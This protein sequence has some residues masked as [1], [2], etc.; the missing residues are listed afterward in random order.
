MTTSQFQAI[1]VIPAAGVGARMGADVPKQ[2]LSCLGKPLMWY[3]LN[4]MQ[5]CDWITEIFVAISP[6]DGYWETHIGDQFSKVS[7]VAGGA[8]RAESVLN[9]LTE[10]RQRHDSNIWTLVHDAARPC[11]FTH[12]LQAIRQA[13][14]SEAIDGVI[15][16]DK[17]H[18]TV[19][20]QTSDGQIAS[21]VDRSKLWRAQTPQVFQLGALQSALQSA[22]LA[23][24][25]DEASAMESVSANIKLLQ[26]DVRNIKVTQPQDLALVSLYLAQQSESKDT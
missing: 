15:L 1:A 21:T 5:Q 9:A 6:E 19:K 12:D 7:C 17:I 20:L 10:A 11:L 26:G 23:T 18:D 4:Q 2:Y 24:V 14:L 13:L 16:A 22:D 3:V 8:S 25:T